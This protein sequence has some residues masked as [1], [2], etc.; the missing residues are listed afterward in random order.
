MIEP[1]VHSPQSV[2]LLLER[3]LEC[4]RP[5]CGCTEWWE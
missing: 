3:E 2:A 5:G 4:L 1:R